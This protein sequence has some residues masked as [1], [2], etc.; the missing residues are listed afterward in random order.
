MRMLVHL[1]GGQPQRQLS[2][3]L[4]PERS[5]QIDAIVTRSPSLAIIGRRRWILLSH[6][7]Q[8]T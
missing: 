5:R 8:N 7:A 2:D 3:I 6:V 4:A 1:L